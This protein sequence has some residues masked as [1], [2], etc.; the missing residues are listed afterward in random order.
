[1][2]ISAQKKDRRY[3]FG[4]VLVDGEAHELFSAGKPVE[5]EPKAFELLLLLAERPEHTFTKDEIAAELWPG[6]IISD[7]VISQCVR[8]TRQACGDSAGTQA[9]IKTIHG[10]GY[11]FS[12]PLLDQTDSMPAEGRLISRLRPALW[13]LTALI[14]AVALLSLPQ[15]PDSLPPGSIIVAALPASEAG[16]LAEPMAAGLESLLSRG[17]GEHSQVQWVTAS[18]TQRMLYALGLDP[19]ADDRVLLDA[20]HEALGADYLVRTRIDQVDDD[21]HLQAELIGNDGKVR[22]L[23]PEIGDIAAMVRGFSLELARE[24]GIEWQDADGIRVLSEDNFVNQA[25][26]RA[27]DALLAGDNQTAASL[28]ESVLNLDPEL[29]YARYELGNAH[30]QLGDHDQARTL[31]EQAR[32]AALARETPRLAGHSASMLGVLDWQAGDFSA[33]EGWYETALEHYE[34]IAD[35]HGAA[36][37]LGNLGNLADSRGDLDRA[38]DLHL[39]ARERF[40]AA[41]DQVGESATYT[42]LAVISRLLGRIHEAHR[43]QQIAVDMQ[44]RLNI[45]SM[46]VRSLTYL[47]ALEAELGNHERALELLDEAAAMA[48]TQGN[49]HGLAEAE[50]ERAR[51]ALIQL[52]PITAGAHASLARDAFVELGMP[53]GQVLALAALAESALLQADAERAVEYLDQADELD[54]NISKPRDRAERQLLRARLLLLSDQHQAALALLEPL[55]EDDH[56]IVAGLA[57]KWLA[58]IHWRENRTE[59]ALKA[60]QQALQTSERLDDP[61]AHASIR[62]RMARALLDSGE[63]EQAE[64]HLTRARSW[65]DQAVKVQ[66]QQARLHLQRNQIEQ[67]AALVQ[68]MEDGLTELPADPGYSALVGRLELGEEVAEL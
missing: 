49:R 64:R 59:Q 48:D 53:A 30:W 41:H 66:I 26:V 35:H 47:A 29:V 36:S 63:T 45:G 54:L 65:S 61:R 3:R 17:I 40:R 67:A 24:L 21:Y 8:K 51:L 7:S 10:V 1:M 12:A 57:L 9:V 2:S 60:W 55:A 23:S 11:R 15:R 13:A 31:Y 19:A 68:A 56:A 62:V 4:E 14:V 42:N 27:L 34:L 5:I 39:M 18:R 32:L 37:S 50:L 28:F 25:Y 16:V 22:A 33:A 20:L 44:R 38:A 46:L 43:N 58:E 52:A 6:R